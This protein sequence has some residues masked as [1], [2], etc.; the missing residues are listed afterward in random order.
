LKTTKSLLTQLL[1][2]GIVVYDSSG[3]TPPVAPEAYRA[4]KHGTLYM[5]SYYIPPAPGSTP[6]A[7][8]W[9]P[10]GKSIGV[11]MQG[12]IW[13]VDPQTG[14]AVEL[15]NSE[16]YAASPDWSPDGK[17]IVYTADYSG[18]KVQLEILNVATGESHALTEDG[19]IYLD[20]V[21]SPDGSRL[22]ARGET[23]CFQ[24]A[25]EII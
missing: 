18:K 12:S 4:V 22:A 16:G 5:Y 20:P 23:G 10:D 14:S 1:L 6:W 19:Q 21:F 2:A 7:P 13:R 15:T 8:C 3:Q 17:W 25:T 9:S 11:G 24:A